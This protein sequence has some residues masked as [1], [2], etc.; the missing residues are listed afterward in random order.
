MR[1]SVIGLATTAERIPRCA[2]NLR[3]AQAGKVETGRTCRR[4]LTALLVLGLGT[5][6]LSVTAVAAPTT[7]SGEAPVANQSEAARAGALKTA[8]AEV[9]MRL[10]GDPGILARS[11]VATAV[12]AADK[13]VLQYRYRRDSVTDEASGMPG[14]RLVL[15]AEFDSVAVDRLL[16][17]FG[18]AGSG[19]SVAIDATPVDKRIWL[20][21]IHSA[22]DYARARGYLTRQAQV[23]QS[24]PIEARGDGILVHLVLAGDFNRWLNVVGVDAVLQ[25]NSA[26]PPVQGIDATLA[27][28]P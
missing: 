15:V 2:R 9:V 3:K 13:L 16:A 10:T 14:S 21:G 17:G 4:W 25:V 24:W 11:E 22:T 27:L 1:A 23:R 8:L 20:S 19:S 6:L 26:S 12:A 7:Y 28:S 18:F 5:G